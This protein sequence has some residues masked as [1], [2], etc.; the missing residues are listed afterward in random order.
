MQKDCS[1]NPSTCIFEKEKY[2]KIIA[3][4]SVITYDEVISVM[5]IVSTK[6]TNTIATNIPPGTRR[7]SDFSFRSHIGRDVADYAETSS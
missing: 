6:M 5:D 7:R 1:W 3:N 4:T 2:L